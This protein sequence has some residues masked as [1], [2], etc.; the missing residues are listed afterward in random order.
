[1]GLSSLLG[2]GGPW[3]IVVAIADVAIVS[4]VIYRVLLLIKGTKAVPMLVGLGMITIAYFASKWLGLQTFHWLV[5]QFLSYSLLFGIIVIFQND[6][7]RG[8]ARLG[9]GWSLVYDRAEEASR[10]EEVIQASVALANARCG[11]L[12]V[13]EREADL[14]EV[15]ASGVALDA[16]VTEELLRTLFLKGSILHDGAVVIS[17]GRIAAAKCMLPLTPNPAIDADLGTRHR[18]AIGLTEEVD[19]AVIVVSEE[20]GQI[21][22]AVGGKLHRDIDADVLRRYLLRLYAP[23]RRGKLPPRQRRA[24]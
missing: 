12:I 11:A 21:S 1:M 18:S 13:L 6:I 15:V 10:V 23:P 3:E 16:E 22:L 20:R 8:L 5:S 9:E 17:R 7:R 2:L 24:A 19:A 14:S 4:Y